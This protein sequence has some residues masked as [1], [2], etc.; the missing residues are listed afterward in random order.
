M[1]TERL[2]S[3]LRSKQTGTNNAKLSHYVDLMHNVH[4]RV[5]ITMI[6]NLNGVQHKVGQLVGR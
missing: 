4:D 2:V 5:S 3:R 6:S 1:N